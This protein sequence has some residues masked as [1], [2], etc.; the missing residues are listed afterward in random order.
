MVTVDTFVR[1]FRGRA[2]AYGSWAGGCVRERLTKE[3]FDGHLRSSAA[4]DWIGVYN[5]I[6]R[7][8]SWGVVDIDVDDQPL[9]LNIQT[10]LR[11][12]H[13]PSWVEK[14]THGYHVWVFPAD[15]L[16]NTATMRKALTAACWAVNYEPKEVFPKQSR[17]SATGLGNYVRL[18]LNGWMSWRLPETRFFLD[19]PGLEEMDRS[20]AQTGDLVRIAAYVPDDPQPVDISVDSQAGLEVQYEVARL[21][22]K[23]RM[24]WQHGP[25]WG[26][27]RSN[28]LVRLAY[29][30]H[31][32]D[33]EP[34]L[35]YQV[36]VS[37]DERW[38]KFAERGE[39]GQLLL[40][41]IITRGYSARGAVT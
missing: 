21:G 36:V 33:V 3:H 40:K 30:L 28:T 19:D 12:E 24:L 9:A 15:Y 26:H 29:E 37:A 16:V 20:R 18:P 27:D 31:E 41:R 17:V 32:A 6:G 11:A 39:V 7:D 8:C 14:T 22:G 25:R 4:A 1:L 5:V 13:V 38:G 23:I 35:A 2:D 10:A 34:A